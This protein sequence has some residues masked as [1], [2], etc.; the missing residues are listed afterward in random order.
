M[1]TH[2]AETIEIPTHSTPR[3]FAWDQDKL[4]KDLRTINNKAARLGQLP[5]AVTFSEPYIAEVRRCW[6]DDEGQQRSRPVKV[7]LLDVYIIGG[8][9]RV[10]GWEFVATVTG[11]GQD[12]KQVNISPMFKGKLPDRFRSTDS[13]CQHCNNQRQR[14]EVYI[15]RN[16]GSGNFKQVG[17]QCLKD[18]LGSSDVAAVLK[19]I[20]QIHDL[21]SSDRRDR[22]V[23]NDL[24]SVVYEEADRWL[25][26]TFACL[27]A[28][29]WVPASLAHDSQ[30]KYTSTRARVWERLYTKNSK[31]PPT[32]HAEPR[33]YE[34]ARECQKWIREHYYREDGELRSGLQDFDYNL[35]TCVQKGHIHPK[36]LGIATYAPQAY[37]KHLGKVEE[38]K[39]QV[40]LDEYFGEV[41]KMVNLE[42]K[43][44]AVI[45]LG[46]TGYGS[47]FLHIARD[48]DG[49]T[50][51]WRRDHRQVENYG[52][53]IKIRAKVKKHETRYNKFTNTDEKQTV[54]SLVKVV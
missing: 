28:H 43:V 3:I 35:A 27:E 48:T 53:T 13:T 18:F 38:R 42:I 44:T 26:H 54:L 47:S 37:L 15:L 6:V 51:V 9:P 20:D 41:G 2:E 30:G 22:C 7:E 10:S 49:R 31:Y 8:V 29:G 45:G 17:K 33:H 16:T 23:V 46:D 4:L 52:D 12:F 24:S 19:Y 40:R 1:T 5:V 50:F 34:Q 32:F 25:A 11:F 39:K 21:M 14:R 36:S